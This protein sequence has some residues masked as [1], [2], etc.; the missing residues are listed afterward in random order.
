M[1]TKLTSLF[2]MKMG[3][4]RQEVDV[5]LY[6][7]PETGIVG[8]TVSYNCAS[9]Q[10]NGCDPDLIIIDHNVPEDTRNRLIDEVKSKNPGVTCFVVVDDYTQSVKATT[11]GADRAFLSDCSFLEFLLAI[12]GIVSTEI[13]RQTAPQVLIFA[14]PGE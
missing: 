10:L 3:F 6:S 1:N 8:Q 12:S 7:I 9:L 14:Q 13:S 5:K 2:A 11:Y 4:E